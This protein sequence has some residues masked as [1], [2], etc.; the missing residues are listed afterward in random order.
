[1]PICLET[2]RETNPAPRR[3]AS[4]AFTGVLPERRHVQVDDAGLPPT[5]RTPARNGDAH[6][7]LLDCRTAYPELRVLGQLAD[8]ADDVH[9]RPYR[10][11]Y[12]LFCVWRRAPRVAKMRRL[13]P[14]A[15][16]ARNLRRARERA[17]LSQEALAERAGIH[18][19]AV[20]LIETGKRDPRLSTA[21]KLAKALGIPLRELLKG[22]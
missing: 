5:I 16:F 18:R 1:M 20:A 4:H 12:A 11:V 22:L 15:S 10:T 21:V 7:A 19:N 6:A 13:A 8:E 3:Q 17:S 2:T 9:E 14:I